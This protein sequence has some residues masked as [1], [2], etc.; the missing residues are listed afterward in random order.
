M[1][2]A[3]LSSRAP[4]TNQRK[5][6]IRALRSLTSTG[7]RILAPPRFRLL[8]SKLGLTFSTAPPKTV[9]KEEIVNQENP[10]NSIFVFRYLA[11]GMGIT[12]GNYLRRVLVDY[13]SG[14]APCG[15]KITDK[16]GSA[17]SKFSTLV[18]V[19]EV[20][21]ELILNLKQMI[22]AEK[23]K[24]TGIFCLEMSIENKA[25]SEKIITAGDFA[26]EKDIEIKNPELYLATLAPNSSLEIQLYCQ[27]NW[28]YHRAEEQKKEY[29]ADEE[30]IISLDTDYSPIKGGR[31]NFQKKAVVVGLA[32]EKEE[33]IL[34]INT[35]G[36]I[37][38]KKA[39]GEAL[40]LSQE[41]FAKIANLIN[42]EK[43]EKIITEIK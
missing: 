37:K 35:N 41:L 36:A 5:T 13:L 31:V 16:N 12:V 6:K 38:P 7:T 23:K 43:K 42:K 29:F 22:L 17:K 32:K 21:P 26:S 39:L 15:V 34:T 3:E 28:G 10:N 19:K 20:V 14:I 24:K 11:T 2:L 27:K 25:K 40:E 9:K 4:S 1:D 33:L 30:D 8:V 18:G